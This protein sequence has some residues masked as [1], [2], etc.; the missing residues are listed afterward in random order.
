MQD[1]NIKTKVVHS[2]KNSA[3]NVIGTSLNGKYKIARCPYVTSN[4]I[5]VTA[6]ER[7][8]ARLHAEFISWC[9]NNS[10]KI[11]KNETQQKSNLKVILD[12]TYF[13]EEFFKKVETLRNYMFN[14][15]NETDSA[16]FKWINDSQSMNSGIFHYKDTSHQK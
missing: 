4:E 12:A 9:F 14:T 13:D 16:L 10:S 7:D 11:L 2:E 8:E 5:V 6:R 15:E 3:W 1:P